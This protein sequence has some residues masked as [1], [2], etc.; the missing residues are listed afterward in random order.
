MLYVTNT[1]RLFSRVFLFSRATLHGREPRRP[2]TPSLKSEKPGL[3]RQLSSSVAFTQQTMNAS[4]RELQTN[5]LHLTGSSPFASLF[6]LLRVQGLPLA[7]GLTTEASIWTLEEQT[8][9]PTS[10]RI[11]SSSVEEWIEARAVRFL[12]T[13]FPSRLQIRR[14]RDDFSFNGLHR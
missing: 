6:L 14:I 2:D 13:F 11:P 9:G 4:D 3:R 5:Q 1:I 12:K 8:A 10:P 7:T